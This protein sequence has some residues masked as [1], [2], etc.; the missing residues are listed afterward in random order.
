[1][2]LTPPICPLQLLCADLRRVVLDVLEPADLGRLA[3]TCRSWRATV[4][5][6]HHWHRACRRFYG[7]HTLSRTTWRQ[8]CETLH[9][10]WVDHVRTFGRAIGAVW[11]AVQH[12]CLALGL[13]AVNALTSAD[14]T[15]AFWVRDRLRTLLDTICESHHVDAAIMYRALL[16]RRPPLDIPLSYERLMRAAYAQQARIVRMDLER[17]VPLDHGPLYRCGNTALESAVAGAHHLA[18]MHHVYDHGAYRDLVL[19]LASGGDGLSV[20]RLADVLNQAATLDEVAFAQILTVILDRFHVA[21]FV[22]EA[23][24]HKASEARRSVN[25]ALLQ[26]E[27]FRM[28]AE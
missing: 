21:D 10:G 27:L 24:C 7:R 3:A 16:A 8:T 17:G 23:A 20:T 9:R 18:Q 12:D 5:D 14:L 28:E 19:M 13:R 6:D 2:D 22:L 4:S 1:M 25:R 26:A 11:F 15:R